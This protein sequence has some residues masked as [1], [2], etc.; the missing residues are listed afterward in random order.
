MVRFHNAFMSSAVCLALASPTVALGAQ[1]PPARLAVGQPS[2]ANKRLTRDVWSMM[3]LFSGAVART[4]GC[5]DAA[6]LGTRVISES[7][8]GDA[9]NAVPGSPYGSSSRRRR[10]AIRCQRTRA[11]A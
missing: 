9:K 1:D 7:P 3:E 8:T 10:A 6:K 5:K 11:L 2:I 4:A